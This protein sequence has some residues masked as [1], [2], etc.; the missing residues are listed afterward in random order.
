MAYRVVAVHQPNY[1]PWIGYFHKIHE[2]DAF[3]WLDD[4][5]Y[6]S[7]SWINRNRLKTPDGWA[8]LTVPVENSDDP[9]SQIRIATQENWRSEHWKTISHNYGAANH[10]D[11]WKQFLRETFDQEWDCLAPLNRHLVD[12]VCERLRLE[13]SFVSAASL[14]IDAVGSQRIA[15]LCDELDADVYLCGMGA[16]EYMDEADFENVGVRVEYQS[17]EH[18]RYEQRF[19]GFIPNL[20]FFDA[21]LNIG[22]EGARD[23]L[24]A[25]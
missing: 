12:E 3:V 6:T 2:S 22:A 25:L 24:M 1:F 21:I 16:D 4:V 11:D 23:M 8:W 5:Q 9:I 18:P 10:Y 17:F 7:G 19:D 14:G 20:S 13:T 15:A